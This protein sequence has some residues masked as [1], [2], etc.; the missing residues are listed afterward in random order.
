MHVEL[1]N[2]KIQSGGR[3]KPDVAGPEAT[4]RRTD[5]WNGRESRRTG[6]ARGRGRDGK[7]ER[8]VVSPRRTRTEAILM[9]SK[10]KVRRGV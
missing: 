6:V 8:E 2:R 1:W 7:H 10:P 3:K 4:S 9:S 5:R